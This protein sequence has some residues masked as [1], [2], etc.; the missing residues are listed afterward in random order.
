MSAESSV[1][2]TVILGSLLHNVEYASKVMPH[3]KVDFFES[4]SHKTL[5]AVSAEYSHKYGSM[6]T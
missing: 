6:P 1:M 3:A 2:E 5:F 4:E